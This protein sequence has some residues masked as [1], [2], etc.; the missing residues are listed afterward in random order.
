MSKYA[1][2]PYQQNQIAQVFQHWA[3]GRKRV[4]MQSGT[5]TGKTV[6][7]NH[8]INLAE[9]KGKRVLVLADR[10][11]LITQTWKR[12][13]D[14]HGIHAGIIMNGHPQVYQLPVQIASVQ[15]I[16]RRNF[17]PDIDLIVID[18]CRS[19]VSPTYEPIFQFYSDAHVL[20]VDAT[21]VR[22]SGAGF[23]HIYQALVI[24]KG[25]KEMESEGALVPAKIFRNPIPQTQLDK[26]KVTAG[27]YNEQQLSALMSQESVISDL[28]ASRE[29][30]APGKKTLV[31][32]VD[33]KHSKLIVEQYKKAGIAAAHVDGESSTEERE[34]LFN[35]LKI[36]KIE[37]LSNVGIA[38]YGVDL[39]WLEVVQ[40]AR[41]T[42][43]LALY[44]QMVGRG[45]RPCKETGKTHYR[46]LDHA[47]CIDEHGLP[48]AERKW[49]LKPSPKRGKKKFILRDKNGEERI[50]KG[51]EI[52]EQM[53][54]M[55]LVE[56]DE[57]T[58]EFYKNRKNFDKIFGALA[59]NGH[60]PLWAYFKY[61]SKYPDALGRNELDYIGT[62]LGFKPG[63]GYYKYKELQEKKA[64]EESKS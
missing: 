34:Y 25:I 60:K 30:W 11:G 2:R 46:L 64:L 41:P 37:V 42:K 26:I 27:D 56:M 40:L 16:T 47:N 10:R 18:E 23:D 6:M 4:L 52:P 3:A 55:E 59:Y 43:S 20:G 21:P 14:A 36:G 45:A 19:S 12:L 39:P 32:A 57:A 17:P 13:W 35:A 29:K 49:T 62:K 28:V 15:T 7:F 8:I 38:T 61:A 31:F 51:R 5:G 44:L 48:N 24:G 50:V 22:T 54:G 33:I 53:E 9:K 63:W 1:L 58:M